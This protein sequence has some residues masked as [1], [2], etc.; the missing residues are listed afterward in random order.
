MNIKKLDR[1]DF[2]KLGGFLA[3]GTLLPATTV[4]VFA[5]GLENIQKGLVRVVWLQGQSCSGCSV[6]LLNSRNP[7]P[8]ALLTRVISLVFHQTVGAA[9]GRTAMD[10]LEKAEK[11]GGYILVMEGSI[12]MNMPEACTIDGRPLTEI[13]DRLI[14][15]SAAVAAVGTCASFGGIPSAEGNPTG[16]ASVREFM[17]KKG[18]NVKSRLVNLPSCPCHPK[19]MIGTI[20]YVAAAGYPKKIN[21]E[22]LTPDIFYAHSVHDE[23]P[24]YHY[25]ERKIFS[26]YLGDPKGCLFKLGCLGPLSYTQCPHRQWNSGVNWCI[27]AAAPCIGCSN[28][29]FAKRKDFA[30]YRK[31]EK[32]HKA[33]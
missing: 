9:Q 3:A 11:E 16:A 30:F 10:T 23:C 6:S 17:E 20:A 1:R 32:H 31:G 19:S 4:R 25:Y 15:K 22:L 18:I 13:L 29:G 12:P 33:N 27:R 2:L 14:S 8:A 21:Q 7:D 24:R 26:S 5:A 28:P